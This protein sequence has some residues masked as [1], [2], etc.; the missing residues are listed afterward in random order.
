MTWS[1]HWASTQ[2]SASPRSPGSAPAWTSRW[3]RSAA[4]P[5]TTS[6][7]PTSTSTPP[8]FTSR[9][10]TGQVVSMAVVVVATGIA[11]DGSR[12]VLGLD[13]GDSEDETF[14]RGF[15]TALKQRGLGGVKLV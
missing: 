3:V 5:W 8:T 7:F 15:L 1:K 13:V 12:E 14:W 10:T 11:A 9:V 6:S 2:G 4:A